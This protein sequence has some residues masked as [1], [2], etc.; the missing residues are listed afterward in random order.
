M[1]DKKDLFFSSLDDIKSDNP[2]TEFLDENVND[3]LDDVESNN[4]NG[5]TSYNIAGDDNSLSKAMFEEN[6]YFVQSTE[7]NRLVYKDKDG[8]KVFKDPKTGKFYNSSNKELTDI[9]ES[10]LTPEGE[11]QIKAK[12][13]KDA[14]DSLNSAFREA[15]ASSIAYTFGSFHNLLLEDM[16]DAFFR[17]QFAQITKFKLNHLGDWVFGK[18][19]P[20]Y[21]A[22]VLVKFYPYSDD[23]SKSGESV[24]NYTPS[25]PTKGDYYQINNVIFEGFEADIG[26]AEI[27]AKKKPAPSSSTVHYK[28]SEISFGYNSWMQL[29]E[30]DKTSADLFGNS[31]TWQHFKEFMS[32]FHTIMDRNFG[33]EIAKQVV[34]EVVIKLV[35]TGSG[36][37][38]LTDFTTCYV[39]R[40]CELC[41]LDVSSMTFDYTN[42]SKNKKGH[43]GFVFSGIL[44]NV[45]TESDAIAAI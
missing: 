3:K 15:T 38:K 30:E 5:S 14:S 22:N 35:M 37:S 16:T 20:S 6:P 40:N 12:Y 29:I 43:F 2:D 21:I 23:L 4:I 42:N 31:G 26:A 18:K 7:N 19:E 17:D 36:T 28:K 39:F 33:K 32:A 34:A 27:A 11:Y 44:T 41:N 8:E 9:D 13:E 45:Y 24:A 10:E 1:S 25:H